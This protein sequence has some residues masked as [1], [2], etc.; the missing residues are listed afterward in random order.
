LSLLS[1][2]IE[3]CKKG[4]EQSYCT[5]RDESPYEEQ[6]N[7]LMTGY[8]LTGLR[9]LGGWP[10]DPSTI[11]IS[12]KKFKANLL[13]LHF[14][15]LPVKFPGD[16]SSCSEDHSDCGFYALKHVIAAVSLTIPLCEP[17]TGFNHESRDAAAFVS[18]ILRRWGFC[19][20]DFEIIDS[21]SEADGNYDD[22]TDSDPEPDEE[23]EEGGFEEESSEDGEGNEGGEE[24]IVYSALDS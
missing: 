2:L 4:L 5:Y 11:R 17:V 1:D 16:N 22:P 8:L 24:G 7:I 10:L 14:N 19:R 12:A 21:D 23:F 6:C 9:S 20:R 15:A 3:V 13:G 18:P